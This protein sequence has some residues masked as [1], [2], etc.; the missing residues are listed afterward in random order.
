MFKWLRRYWWAVLLVVL[1]LAVGGFVMW[2]NTTS[3]PMPEAFAALESDD[4]IQVETDPWLVF[5]PVDAEPTS[6]F[7]IYPG[8]KV[9]A[10]SY[11]PT[12]R[13]VAEE[14]YLAVIVPMPLHLAVIAPN[15]ALD[16][17]AAFPDVEHWVVGGHSLGGAMAARFVHSN[18]GA[19]DGL[20]IW[21]S[22]PDVSNDLSDFDLPVASIYGSEDGLATA[23][24]VESSA[25][26]LP[27][28]TV[29]VRIEGGNH[30]QFGWYGPQYRD[31]EALISRDEQQAQIV[32]ATLDVLTAA[33][34]SE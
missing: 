18:P 19:A 14:G 23:E 5:S 7:I 31:N 25:D 17:M 12:A 33:S 9:D 30:A 3:E 10:R 32:A 28:D 16:V 2:A 6:G 24:Q 26:L 29:W 15:S 1:V 21:A 22:Y 20:V 27:V 34:E 13:A 11:A 8:G 4:L